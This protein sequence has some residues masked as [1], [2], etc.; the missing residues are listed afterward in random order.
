MDRHHIAH[1]A[2]AAALALGLGGVALRAPVVVN[3]EHV[4]R[5][6][7]HVW[8]PL[9]P[10]QQAGLAA[11]LAPL[12]LQALGVYCLDDRCDD[13]AEDVEAAAKA[14]GASPVIER[15]ITADPGV[16]V[17]AADSVAALALAD[18]IRAGTGGALNPYIEARAAAVPFI[19]F[20]RR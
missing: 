15:P 18:A 11:A 17:G 20:G 5:A 12:R 19:S 16:T 3:A 13:L 4:G 1:Y 6:S 7:A 2:L 14:A 10:A 9:T 8:T